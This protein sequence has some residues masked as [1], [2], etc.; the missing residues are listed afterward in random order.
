MPRILAAARAPATLGTG[1]FHA[2]S[3]GGGQ[4]LWRPPERATSRTLGLG[5]DIV[6]LNRWSAGILKS[7]SRFRY[8]YF[9]Y[10]SHNKIVQCPLEGFLATMNNSAQVIWENRLLRSSRRIPL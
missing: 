1:N 7:S 9:D 8:R 3:I 5:P 4:Y 6:N 2:C 10:Y